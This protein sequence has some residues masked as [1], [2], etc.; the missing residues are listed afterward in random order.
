M[1]TLKKPSKGLRPR[2]IESLRGTKSTKSYGRGIIR[3]PSSLIDIFVLKKQQNK[4]VLVMMRG[5]LA[6]LQKLVGQELVNS[7]S[8]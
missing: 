8:K 4:I 1:S 5:L 2:R 6:D 7:C 3:L